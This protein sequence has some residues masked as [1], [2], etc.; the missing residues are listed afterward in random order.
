MQTAV[1]FAL[2]VTTCLLVLPA[3]ASAKVDKKYA[4]SYAGKVLVITETEIGHR[5][6]YNAYVSTLADLGTQMKQALASDPSDPNYQ[7]SIDIVAREAQEQSDGWDAEYKPEAIRELAL[8]NHLYTS[9]KGWFSK[10]ADKITFRHVTAELYRGYAASNRAFACLAVAFYDLA[11][12]DV[13][14]AQDENAQAIKIIGPA[15]ADMNAGLSGIK[16]LER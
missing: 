8:V 5:T 7:N 4:K 12:K 14:G 11:Q 10:S 1:V 16:S 3:I 2:A 13:A 9:C 15:E 6:A